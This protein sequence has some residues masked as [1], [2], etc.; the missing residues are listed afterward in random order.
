MTTS[1][2]QS[3]PPLLWHELP[4]TA[5]LDSLQ[6][7]PAGLHTEQVEERRCRFGRNLLPVKSP[8]T[9]LE[10]LLHQF[11]SPLIYILLA[12]SAVAIMIGDLKDAFFIFVVVLL[13]AGLGT[14]QEWKAERSAA[15][16]HQL[17]QIVAHVR[18]NGRDQMIAA[19]ELVPGD[20]VL[21][22]SGQR[23]PADLR[24]LHVNNLTIDE[25]FLTGESLAVEKH[26]QPLAAAAAVSERSNMAFAGATVAT[27][28][29]MGVVVATGLRTE[30]GAIAGAVTAADTTRPP[31][32]IRMEQFAQQISIAVLGASALLA[33]IALGRGVAYAEVFFLAVALAVSAIP[34]GL[35]VA[36]TVALSIATGRMA[37]RNVIVRKLTAVEGLGSCTYIAS[38]KTG[39]LT[40]NQQTVKVIV[41][42]DG[43]RLHV[44]GE[45]VNG[46]GTVTAA[47]GA[48]LDPVLHARLLELTRAAV[49]CNEASLVSENG[50]WDHHG[51]AVDV[52]LLALG[53]KVGLDPLQLRHALDLVG[54][55]PFESERRYAASCYREA[56]ALRLAL[57]GAVET[58]L[59]FCREMQ[60]ADGP[61]ALDTAAVEQAAFSLAADGFRVI[62]LAAGSCDPAVL[63]GGLHAA[64][65]PPLTLLGLVGLIDPLR[66]EAKE[67]VMQ[68][69]QAGISVA[70]IT[71]DHPATALAIARELGI[72][73][74]AADIVTGQMLSE[75]GDPAGAQF[76]ALVQ[77]AQVFARVAPVQ[78]LQIVEA[79][80]RLGHFV[81]VTGDGV[82]DAP[83][84][85]AAN[86]GVAMGSGTDVAKDT[87]SM[88]VTDDNFASIKAGVEEGRFAY[89]NV[90]KVTYLLIS[91]G[92]A[93]VVLF[94]LAIL[95]GLP[96]PLFAVQLLWLNLVTNGIQDVALAFEGGEPGAM[97]RPPRKPSEGIFNRLMIRQTVTSGMTIGL[98]GF[99]TWYWLLAAGYDEAAARNLGLLLMV[100]F[101]NV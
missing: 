30:V 66:P 93:E 1:L 21:I 36:L 28:R 101:E 64:Q 84:L 4:E 63:N 75:S 97:R 42:P 86:I 41:L 79:L 80:N 62:A 89:D 46:D 6:A 19:E 9:L 45:G 90:R 10:I 20:I 27:G 7:T 12:A 33:V 58:I 88:I 73:D 48:A 74:T 8:P 29:G 87:A 35:P 78:K 61:V 24:L 98:I 77:S 59:P 60:S 95:S 53:Y 44:S 82:N 39:T 72:A 92:A 22:E 31:L 17:L 14:F 34:E 26:C 56:D 47:D 71:G 37:Q 5:L 96:L 13:N 15:A 68:C 11:K 23:V 91:T 2:P 16:L 25:S 38:D 81:A 99:G 43:V 76:T 83:A 49:I 51:D 94:T 67:A 55:L 85:R 57:K 50:H 100:L 40:V 3:D 70:M 54:E 18:R 32:V 69:R 52:A 65:I